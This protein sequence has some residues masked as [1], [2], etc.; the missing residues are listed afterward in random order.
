MLFEYTVYV[1]L[2]PANAAFAPDKVAKSDTAVPCGTEIDAPECEPPDNDVD[3]DV[4]FATG[5]TVS[6]SAPQV[7]FDGLF[8]ESPP[9]DACQ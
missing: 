7:L 4:D 6:T 8:S 1:T 5:V 9:Y 2:P 3:N